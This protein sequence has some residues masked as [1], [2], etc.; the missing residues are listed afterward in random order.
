MKH[1]SDNDLFAEFDGPIELE[2]LKAGLSAVIGC[3][4]AGRGPLAGPVV[5]AAVLFRNCDTIWKCKDSKSLTSERRDY[6]YE[7]I[8]TCLEH[9]VVRVEPDIIDDI[10]IRVASLK[11][12]AQA[13]AQLNC[14]ADIVLVDGRDRLPNLPQSRAIVKGDALVATISAASIIAKVSLE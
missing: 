11:G 1:N 5:T 8:V 14:N 9:A 7:E 2:L 10:N 12:M 3:D 13:V 4:E 6:L